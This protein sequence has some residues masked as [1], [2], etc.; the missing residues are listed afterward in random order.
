MAACEQE[1]PEATAAARGGGWCTTGR[2]CGHIKRPTQRDPAADALETDAVLAVPETAASRGVRV[3]MDE[4][5]ER[6]REV[7]VIMLAQQV[8]CRVICVEV[9]SFCMMP[10]L[11][12]PFS[13]RPISQRIPAERVAVE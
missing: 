6:A 8:H 10:H 2:V 12:L 7:A 9:V 3:A 13:H 1:P 11:F 4:R 5:H